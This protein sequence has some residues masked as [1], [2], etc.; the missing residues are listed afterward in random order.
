MKNDETLSRVE[1]TYKKYE[2]LRDA[3]HVS[4]STVSKETGVR[5]S[6][7]SDWKSKRSTPNFDNL[8]RLARFFGVPADY[9]ADKE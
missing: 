2:M 7:L 8:V 1:R 3:K 6:A 5:R 4:D 9:F